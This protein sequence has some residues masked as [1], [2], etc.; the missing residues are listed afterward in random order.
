LYALAVPPRDAWLA[1]WA[2]PG[3]LLV[4][5]RTLGVRR[6][7]VGG[8]IAGVLAAYGTVGWAVDAA[9]AY[10]DF[11]RWR[12]AAFLAGVWL[13]Y[14]GSSFAAMCA[15]YAWVA[16]R[17]RRAWWPFA[18]GCCWAGAEWVRATMLYGLPWLLLGH[19]QYRV[20]PVVQVADLGGVYAVSFIMA[21]TSVAVGEAMV[22]WRQPRWRG[23]LLGSA[24]VVLVA[25]L[26]YG[27]WAAHRWERAPAGTAGRTVAVVQAN[28][29]NEFRWQREFFTRALIRFVAMSRRASGELDL[30]VWPENAVNFYLEREALFRDMLRPVAA[31]AREGLLVGAPRLGD[32]GAARNAAFLVDGQ[33]EVR[34]AYEKHHL[35]P[36]A[37]YRP[38]LFGAPAPT[39]EPRYIR[40]ARPMPVDTGA[41][42][43]GVFICWDSDFAGLV[44]HLVRD[45]AQLL[46]A[47]SNDAW[48]DGPSHAGPEQHLIATVFRAI[49]TR[50]WLVRAASTGV[51]GFVSPAGTLVGA[52]PIGAADVTTARVAV[53]TGLTFYVRFGDAWLLAAGLVLLIALGRAGRTHAPE[54]PP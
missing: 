10:F 2:I 32:D 13:V 22:A 11:E 45:G 50:R 35:L 21:A 29:A 42:R 46:V 40:G 49:E 28:V 44:R 9:L 15:G 25:T 7:A 18:A 30:L 17:L 4:A 1:G 51:S 24:A 14:V 53:G 47:L 48:L 8:V 3:V 41:T 12:A 23:R 33:G 52:L 34:A 20:A 39:S 38:P 6:A 43:L 5:A 27:G 19:T 16:R 31:S 37:E 36:F 26:A 54:P